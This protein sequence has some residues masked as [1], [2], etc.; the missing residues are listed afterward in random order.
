MSLKNET[1]LDQVF[2]ILT[3]FVILYRR[4][5]VFIITFRIKLHILILFDV[6]QLFKRY[7]QNDCLNGYHL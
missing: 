5:S 1:I 6:I 2:A 4:F 7:G 3:K